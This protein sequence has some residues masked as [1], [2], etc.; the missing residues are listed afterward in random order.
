MLKC[1]F[2]IV[3]HS[4]FHKRKLDDSASSLEDLIDT[5]MRK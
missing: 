3:F 4:L 5:Q 1:I 2:E